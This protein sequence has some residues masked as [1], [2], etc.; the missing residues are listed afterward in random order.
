MANNMNHYKARTIGDWVLPINYCPDRHIRIQ[1]GRFQNMLTV[2]R[3]TCEALHVFSSS[4]IQIIV[5]L[6][7]W[8]CSKIIY[9]LWWSLQIEKKC[10]RKFLLQKPKNY[11]RSYIFF[12]KNIIYKLYQIPTSVTAWQV[13]MKRGSFFSS[14]ESSSLV[15]TLSIPSFWEEKICN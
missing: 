14:S 2:L 1:K 13:R 5:I 15:N 11:Q 6:Q 4:N 12:S 8:Y 9:Q 7:Y 10:S 3:C